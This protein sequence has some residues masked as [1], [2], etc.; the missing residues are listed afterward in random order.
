VPIWATLVY[1]LCFLASGACALLL[2]RAFGRSRKRLLLWSA[3]SF[4]TLALN[5]LL[6][7]V[8]LLLLPNVDLRLYR[9]ATA[10]LAVCFLLYGL[11]WESD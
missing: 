10:F 1:V 7:V 6:L 5:N 4:V 9:A 3:A 8:D 11:I 2:V